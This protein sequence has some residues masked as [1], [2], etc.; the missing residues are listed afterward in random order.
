M[1]NFSHDQAAGLRNLVALQ[2]DS[3]TRVITVTG[4][5][6]GVGRTEVTVNLAAALAEQNKRVLLIDENAYPHNICTRLGL[7]ARFDLAHVIR[8]DRKLEQVIVP[9]PDNIFVLPAQRGIHAL[10][11]LNRADQQRLIT[12]FSQITEPIDFILIDT[13]MNAETQVLPLSLASEQVMVV[14]SGSAVSLTGAYAL[15]KIMNREYAKRHFLVFINKAETKLI[16][17]NVFE[18][19]ACIV[20]RY[21]GISPEFA[22]FTELD[23]KISQSRRLCRPALSLFPDSQTGN[24]FRLLAENVLYAPRKD[25]FNGLVESFMQRLIHTSHLSMT[26]LTV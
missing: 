22:G 18:N 20:Q 4:G 26:N 16:A 9:G 24:N 5:A 8:Q 3:S 21:L 11:G 15:I 23:E 12:S 19:F 14:I 1:T 2:T 13:A 10:T 25:Y 17:Q 6:K 7:K